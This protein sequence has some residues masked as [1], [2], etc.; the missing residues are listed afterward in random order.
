[1][2]KPQVVRLINETGVIPV[3]RATTS[4]EAIR[5]ID[6]IREGGISLVEITMTVPGAMRLLEQLSG[7]YGK[8]VVIGAGAVLN[9]ETARV[10]ILSG[11]QFIASPSFNHDTIAACRRAGVAVIPGA[12]TPSEVVQASHAGADFVKVYPANAVG[13]PTY[14]KALKAQLPHIQL[15][16]TGG[17]SLI[18]AADFI[19]GGAAALGVGTEL[20][21]IQAIHEGQPA[22]ITERAKRFLEIVRDARH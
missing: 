8:E 20:F 2:A 15:V 4:D 9:A 7:H 3:V 5:A 17:V 21:N 11:A 6:A 19:R 1:M 14:I 10:S 16:P 18:N 12:L 13:G 22:L